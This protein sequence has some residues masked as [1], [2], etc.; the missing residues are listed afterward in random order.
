MLISLHD[1]TILF[2][3]IEVNILHTVKNIKMFHCFAEISSFYSPSFRL[4]V[5][6]HAQPTWVKRPFKAKNI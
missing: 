2:L 5:Q 6:Y 3:L 1:V 4:R